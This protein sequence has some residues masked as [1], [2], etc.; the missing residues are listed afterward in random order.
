MLTP[1]KVRAIMDEDTA[2]LMLTNPNTLGLFEENI[3]EISDIV[4]REGRLHILRRREPERP[5]GHSQTLGHGSGPRSVQPAQDLLDAPRRRRPGPGP[6]GVVKTLEPY[7]PVP[8][9]V[10]NK[11]TYRLDFERPKTIGRLKAFYGNF[12]IMVRAYAYILSMGKDGLRRASEMAIL[13]ANYIRAKLKDSY[14]LPF[15]RTCMHECVFTDKLQSAKG[16]TTL[17]IAKGSWTSDFTRR[18]YIFRSWCRAR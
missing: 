7:L 5:H 16:V 18:P 13:N 17:D 14:H 11:N 3:R 10:K 9:I 12:A 4:H 1:D 2:A 8:R 6:L 15:E